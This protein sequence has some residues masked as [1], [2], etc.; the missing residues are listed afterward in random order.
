MTKTALYI[1]VSHYH[2]RNQSTLYLSIF[3]FLTAQTKELGFTFSLFIL[4]FSISFLD[5]QVCLNVVITYLHYTTYC[6]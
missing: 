3:L 4:S 2:K 1:C 5:M 6:K